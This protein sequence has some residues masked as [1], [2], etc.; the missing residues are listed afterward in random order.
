MRSHRRRPIA[1]SQPLDVAHTLRLNSDYGEAKQ[2]VDATVDPDVLG[3]APAEF[4]PPP[5]CQCSRTRRSAKS[6]G[7]FELELVS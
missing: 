6:L 1:C 4:C 5:N 3:I 7:Q 2:K